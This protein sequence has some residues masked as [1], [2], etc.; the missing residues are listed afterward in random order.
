MS[1]GSSFFNSV[2]HVSNLVRSSGMHQNC[3][4]GEIQPH[5]SIQADETLHPAKLHTSIEHIKVRMAINILISM[6]SVPE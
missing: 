3:N 2:V 5:L 1:L 6:F 4:A